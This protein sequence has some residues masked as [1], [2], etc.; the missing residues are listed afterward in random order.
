MIRR[1]KISESRR[2]AKRGVCLLRL[3]GRAFLFALVLFF[4]ACMVGCHYMIYYTL[5]LYLKET[6][7]KPTEDRRTASTP[8]KES[9]AG[10]TTK[11]PREAHVIGKMPHMGDGKVLRIHN[12]HAEVLDHFGKR[13]SADRK[14][15]VHLDQA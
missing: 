1:K 4:V 5:T 6:T 8:K 11:P 7:G 2:R 13:V 10:D 12:G 14:G 3:E 9:S 15:H